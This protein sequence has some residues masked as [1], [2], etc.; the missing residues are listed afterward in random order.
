M[1]VKMQTLLKDNF[2]SFCVSH[3]LGRVLSFLDQNLPLSHCLWILHSK[4]CLTLAFMV[5]RLRGSLTGKHHSHAQRLGTTNRCSHRS[6]SPSAAL[7]MLGRKKI[8]VTTFCITKLPSLW[9]WM[10]R[11]YSPSLL[12]M[13]IILKTVTSS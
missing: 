3:C 12:Q 4:I 6:A 9:P 10:T 11:N 5:M 2:V 8:Q 13:L 1:S 7:S